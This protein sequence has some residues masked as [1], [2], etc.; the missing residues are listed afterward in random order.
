MS[1]EEATW[2]DANFIKTSFPEFFN[3]T[4]R[5]WFSSKYPRGQGSHLQERAIVKTLPMLRT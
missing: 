1:P 2:E 5:R 4:I 3:E